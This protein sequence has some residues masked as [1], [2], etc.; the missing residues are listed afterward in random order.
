M[1][2][3]RNW[4]GKH[5]AEGPLPEV[6]AGW[7]DCGRWETWWCSYRRLRCLF[8]FLAVLED[9]GYMSRAAFLMDRMMSKVG[10]HGK[11]FYS[12]VVGVCLRGAGD[13]GDAGNREPAGSAGDDFDFAAHELLGRGCRFIR[14]CLWRCFLGARQ[15]IRP[16]WR[17][18]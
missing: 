2:G 5:M 13:Y 11:A 15:D 16:M 7:G 6:V 9:S 18:W 10:L 3:Y 8:L 17:R 1:V 14:R 4:V 12:A